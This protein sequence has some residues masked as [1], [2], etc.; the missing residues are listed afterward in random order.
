MVLGI[1]SGS[2][3]GEQRRMFPLRAKVAGKRIMVLVV[4]NPTYVFIII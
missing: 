1:G 2:G 4:R 3:L